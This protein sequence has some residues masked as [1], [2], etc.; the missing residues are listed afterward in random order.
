MD[1]ISE[2]TTSGIVI[3]DIEIT[4]NC[5]DTVLGRIFGERRQDAIDQIF[6]KINHYHCFP[7]TK[8]NSFIVK[9]VLFLA[10]GSIYT[11]FAT[12]RC[13]YTCVKNVCLI[14][15]HFFLYFYLFLLVIMLQQALSLQ[16]YSHFM[17]SPY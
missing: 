8:R 16:V 3:A 13:V 9:Y 2:S 4:L 1:S 15:R 7:S 10:I 5:N 14:I 11:V 17:P 6:H 12:F